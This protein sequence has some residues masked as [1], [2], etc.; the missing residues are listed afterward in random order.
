MICACIIIVNLSD[1]FY[2]I[3]FNVA[4]LNNLLFNNVTTDLQTVKDQ[5][6]IKVEIAWISFKIKRISLKIEG[7]S[8]KIKF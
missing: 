4:N 2:V 5:K 6:D 1:D 7:I 8:F 3:I